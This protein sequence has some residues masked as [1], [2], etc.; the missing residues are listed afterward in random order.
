[1]TISRAAFSTPPRHPS[2][3]G[4][5]HGPLSS[6]TTQ[7]PS[8][9]LPRYTS[10]STSPLPTELVLYAS[11]QLTALAARSRRGLACNESPSASVFARGTG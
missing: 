3:L 5:A 10:S 11:V 4:L 6:I 8:T 7:A 1:M 9:L 2:Q